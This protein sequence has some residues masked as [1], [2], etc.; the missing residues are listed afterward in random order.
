MLHYHLIHGWFCG[1]GIRYTGPMGLEGWVNYT[2]IFHCL[3]FGV[4][5]LCVVQ[6][7]AVVSEDLRIMSICMVFILYSENQVLRLR[8]KRIRVRLKQGGY[9]EQSL[10]HTRKVYLKKQ[11]TLNISSFSHWGLFQQEH[12]NMARHC[13]NSHSKPQIDQK[14]LL[15]QLKRTCS[16]IKSIALDYSVPA[17]KLFKK[18]VH[19]H[20]FYN[21]Q[22][23]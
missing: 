9:G 16:V 2:C 7:L 21:F 13:I 5:P 14:Q 6:G 15:H 18:P 17:K 11:F 8:K 20:L 4:P 10:L 3:W 22:N 19:N 1:C 12:R 23:H